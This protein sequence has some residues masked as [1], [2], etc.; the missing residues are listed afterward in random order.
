MIREIAI[1]ENDYAEIC[2]WENEG[3]STNYEI[4]YVVLEHDVQHH[5][6]Q[7][8]ETSPESSSSQAAIA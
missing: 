5:S 4:V 2:C 1:E 8:P 7:P 3:G 6:C